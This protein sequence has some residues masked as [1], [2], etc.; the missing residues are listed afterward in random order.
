MTTAGDPR[1]STVLVCSSSLVHRVLFRS[2]ESAAKPEDCTCVGE[3]D[4]NTHVPQRK[5]FSSTV[6]TL[7]FRA[8]AEY[9]AHF[10]HG[11]LPSTFRLQETHLLS[12]SRARDCTAF[13]HSARTLRRFHHCSATREE[14]CA[15]GV[16]GRAP[17]ALQIFRPGRGRRPRRPQRGR[18][19]DGGRAA[20]AGHLAIA[21]GHARDLRRPPHRLRDAHLHGRLHRKG[22]QR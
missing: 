20:V 6:N 13:A 22:H 7:V 12:Y 16:H 3:E 5:C 8:D 17:R 1:I 4:Q 10:A 2:H 15:D 9:A 19:R 21:A 18:P 11:G 14:G